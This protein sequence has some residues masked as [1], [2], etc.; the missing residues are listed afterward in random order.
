MK[1]LTMLGGVGIL[2]ALYLFCMGCNQAPGKK[3]TTHVSPKPVGTFSYRSS[4]SFADGK[5]SVDSS[6]ITD[7]INLK[8]LYKNFNSDSLKLEYTKKAIPDFAV[9][10]LSQIKK[11]QFVLADPK[12]D[13]EEGDVI[14]RPEKKYNKKLVFVGMRKDDI[15]LVFLQGGAFLSTKIYILRTS[16]NRVTD[17]W[18]ES[19]ADSIYTSKQLGAHLDKVLH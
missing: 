4:V 18:F 6:V 10:F 13:W 7:N 3:S 19:S 8:E 14:S 9:N 5:Y 12:E 16:A 11:K 17:F 15:Y 2:G 1:L